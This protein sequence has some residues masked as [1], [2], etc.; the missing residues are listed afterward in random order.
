YQCPIC[1]KT[2]DRNETVYRHIRIHS[3]EKPYKCSFLNCNK[4]FS[5]K[6]GL[7]HHEQLH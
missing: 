2:F 5:R 6:D 3:V 7:K 4:R 1:L